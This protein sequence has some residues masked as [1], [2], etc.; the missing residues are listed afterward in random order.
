M[1]K[2]DAGRTGKERGKGLVKGERRNHRE[3][4]DDDRLVRLRLERVGV[5]ASHLGAIERN[6]REFLSPIPILGQASR[7]QLI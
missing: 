3:R 1:R 5:A 4:G 6:N 7:C 2:R